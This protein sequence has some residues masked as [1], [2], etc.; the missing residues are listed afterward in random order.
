M[1]H[2]G[3]CRL[4]PAQAWTGRAFLARARRI[5][6]VHAGGTVQ[7]TCPEDAD[8]D[9]IPG[10]TRLVLSIRG[11]GSKQSKK[12]FAFNKMSNKTRF[13]LKS[14]NMAGLEEG[15]IFMLSLA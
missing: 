4:S 2:A 8:K 11:A 5:R 6:A 7:A 9:S 14:L 13:G 1:P 3:A 10:A 15:L 12:I